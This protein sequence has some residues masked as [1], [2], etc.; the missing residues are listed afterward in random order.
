MTNILL[1][2]LL[3]IVAGV[4]SGLIGI[5]GGVL[6]VPALIFLFGLSQ[7]EAQG[8]TLAL[9]VPPIGFLGAWTYYQQGYVNIKIAVWIC[10][11]FFI[12]SL[13]GAKLATNIP[14]VILEKIFGGA[15]MMI[16]LKMIWGQ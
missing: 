4:L 5:G 7:H 12:G 6:I 11:G 15:M 1:Y 10:L 14:N 9:L 8:T 2:L 3:G 13:F 16:A